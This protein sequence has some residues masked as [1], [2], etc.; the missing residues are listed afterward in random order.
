MRLCG[1][2]RRLAVQPCQTRWPRIHS[3]WTGKIRQLTCTPFARSAIKKEEDVLDS[4]AG[5]REELYPDSEHRNW[6]D[7]E[8][9]TM[10]GLLDES[11]HKLKKLFPGRNR[12]SISTMKS[13]LRHETTDDVKAALRLSWRNR[14][15]SPWTTSEVALLEKLIAEKRPKRFMAAT[16]GRKIASINDMIF[17]LRDTGTREIK[18][19]LW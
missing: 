8:I 11:L 9:D 1:L 5:K 17:R 18:I 3:P 16:L 15:C 4:P 10:A 13:R 6:S 19:G 7:E 12:H 14:T 2:S